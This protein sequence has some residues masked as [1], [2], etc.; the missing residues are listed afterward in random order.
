VL[1]LL[2]RDGVINVDVPPHGV[3]SLSSLM[4]YPFAGQA[5]R[6]FNDAGFQVAIVT[7]QSAIGKG[8][9]S[10]EGLSDIHSAIR[11]II[12]VQAGARI[13]AFYHC[14]DHP[15][16]PTHRRKPQGGMLLEAL[17]AF[18]ANPAQTAM[19]GDDWRDLQAAESVGCPAF[20]VLTGKGMQT[21]K[22]VEENDFPVTLCKDLLD[23]SRHIIL[24]FASETF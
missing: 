21:Q 15:D 11:H 4:V 24:Q 8:L 18:H 14:P 16:R 6:A 22:R 5:I 2:D 19:V 20:L 12:D 10:E 9:L 23:A 1:V 7:N 17:A 3:T 13:D